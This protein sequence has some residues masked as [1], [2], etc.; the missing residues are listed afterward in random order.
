MTDCHA[1]VPSWA[2]CSEWPDCPHILTLPP[3]AHNPDQ[4]ACAC[5][6]LFFLS[7]GVSTLAEQGGSE[8]D[9]VKC[10]AQLLAF[11]GSQKAVLKQG[12]RSLACRTVPCTCS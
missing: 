1:A 6:V 9:D 2:Q 7:M 5:K 10:S 8:D 4:A 3:A 11:T 12:K